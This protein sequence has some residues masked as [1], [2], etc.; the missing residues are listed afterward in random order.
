MKLLMS[1]IFILLTLL[2]VVIYIYTTTD[3][4]I[5]P[6]FEDEENQTLQ[7]EQNITD[8][9]KI[10]RAFQK[11]YL[12]S[13]WEDVHSQLNRAI[14]KYMELDLAKSGSFFWD[15]SDSIREEIYLIFDEIV[16]ELKDERIAQ[17]RETIQ[18]IE[19][20]IAEDTALIK[21]YELDM[22][23]APKESYISTTVEEYKANIKELEEKIK[24][25][26]E[27]IARTQENIYAYIY[28][29]GMQLP[30]N[31]IDMLSKRIDFQYMFDAA[32][33]MKMLKTVMNKITHITK[34][35]K[36][37]YEQTLYYHNINRILF[38]FIIYQ[39]NRYLKRIDDTQSGYI[40]Q[41]NALIDTNTQIYEES[42][43]NMAREKNPERKKIYA[44][45]MKV[46]KLFRQAAEI[47]KKDLSLQR[48]RLLQV[49]YMAAKHLRLTQ[50][51]YKTSKL[52]LESLKPMRDM[53]QEFTKIIHHYFDNI[54]ITFKDKRLKKK[55]IEITHKLH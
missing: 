1:L 18:E 31:K 37:T 34:A 6:S 27:T 48:T 2:S 23:D 39:Q 41:L 11:K 52:S 12:E 33:V 50:N 10:E 51:R 43:L 15:K 13:K 7:E 46:L 22:K 26:K 55:Y 36:Y 16:Q 54:E 28:V 47:Y 53:N 29:L 32:L 24:N 35:K 45:N 19:E 5:I 14:E 44:D 42:A 40:T 20:D 25:Q 4:E 38:E 30:Y 49:R 8:P 9:K 21:E 17:Y 3:I